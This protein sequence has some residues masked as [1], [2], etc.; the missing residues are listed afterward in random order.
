MEHYD[1]IYLNECRLWGVVP[2][3]I[4][5]MTFLHID[6]RP[7]FAKHSI[8]DVKQ[9]KIAVIDPDFWSRQ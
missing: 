8:E 1:S 3:T 6:G 2:C 5:L 7:W 4:K 9:V